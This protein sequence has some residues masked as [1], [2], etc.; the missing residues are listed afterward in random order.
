MQLKRG[1]LDNNNNDGD[2]TDDTTTG[3]AMDDAE[4]VAA[5]EERSKHEGEWQVVVP[6]NT[7]QQQQQEQQ[8]QQIIENNDTDDADDKELGR[9][10]QMLG[11]AL[12]NSDTRVSSSFEELVVV[13]VEDSE[14][15][16]DDG[17]KKVQHR[18]PHNHEAVTTENDIPVDQL[19]SGTDQ[20]VRN[21]ELTVRTMVVQMGYRKPTEVDTMSNEDCRNTLIMELQNITG[22]TVKNLQAKSNDELL[23][24]F[25]LESALISNKI[26]TAAQ[27]RAMKHEDCRN[28]LIVELHKRT[29]GQTIKSLQTKKDA[30]LVEHINMVAWRADVTARCYDAWK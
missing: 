2:T 29:T 5:R 30:E 20:L 16:D 1:V 21:E 15:K 22:R 12:F 14:K 7:T 4:V 18:A 17:D 23:E 3:D 19:N 28:T 26:R 9:A 25:A 6:E 27:V 8:Q 11:P 13:V 10:T 24:L